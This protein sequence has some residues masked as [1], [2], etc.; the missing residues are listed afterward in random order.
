[1]VTSDA[2]G[3]RLR[4]AP[5]VNTRPRRVLV[6]GAGF[7]GSAVVPAL[8]ERGHAAVALTRS[9][10][11]PERE[12]LLEQAR[13]VVS[14]HW[15][16]ALPNL[17]ADADDLIYCVGSASPTESEVDP[18]RDISAVLPPL[19]KVLEL[20][21]L[22]PSTR[23]TFLS[24]G[25]TVYG[26]NPALPISEQA[27]TQPIS[28]YGILKLACENYIHMYAQLHDVE[29]RILRVS[30]PYGPTQDSSTGQ[31]L[32]ARLFRNAIRGEAVVLFGGGKA[33]RDYLHVDDLGAA[34]AGSLSVDQLPRVLNIG[35]GVG[36]SS[37]EV[38]EL[39]A[40]ATGADFEIRL[41]PPRG[42]DVRAN[43]LDVSVAKGAIGYTARDL[44]QGLRDTW[45]VLQQ[46]GASVSKGQS[47]SL[48]RVDGA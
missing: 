4:P 48:R 22:H 33:V 15:L 19:A 23:L 1:V 17:L 28:S 31:G 40:E 26:D 25:G 30:N 7:I 45:A 6:L 38:V 39:V 29:A 14:E 44:E 42:Y 12:Q 8:I 35:S 34:I 10:P 46:K 5:Q 13:V 11:R 41:D 37:L 9:H 16:Q 3:S 18:A 24:S 27:P 47:V 36:H 2:R 21:R 32:V 43:V 20:L